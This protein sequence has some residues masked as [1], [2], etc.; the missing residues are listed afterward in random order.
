MH[1]NLVLLSLLGLMP[2]TNLPADQPIDFN[3]DIRPLLSGNCLVCHG[4]D[5]A[6]RAADLRLDT[7]N[8]SRA[9]LGGYAAVVPGDPDESEMIVRLT[10]DD[11]DLRMPPA[12]KGRPLSD[13]EVDLIRR[14]IAQ[15]G[16][17]ARHWAY[18]KPVRPELPVVAD[19]H[20][21]RNAVD[22]F[23]LSLIHI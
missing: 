9:D 13:R 2:G 6:E 10:S 19:Q 3:R 1:R 5:E 14:W 21:P 20:W 16:E 7:Q 22:H 4:P 17:Y 11:P 15:G 8:G 23:I 18:Q 12:G